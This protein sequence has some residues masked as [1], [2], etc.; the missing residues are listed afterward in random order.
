MK[1]YVDSPHYSKYF[2][3][4]SRPRRLLFMFNALMAWPRHGTSLVVPSYVRSC[5]RKEL[6]QAQENG[7]RFLDTINNKAPS[8]QDVGI[9]C[10]YIYYKL[11]HT[12]THIYIYICMIYDTLFYDVV[13]SCIFAYFLQQFASSNIVQLCAPS[14]AK[15]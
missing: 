12:H 3:V 2:A 13:F 11:Y 5:S 8:R 7:K 15:P 10:I 6:L 14:A 1:D 9:L 4:L